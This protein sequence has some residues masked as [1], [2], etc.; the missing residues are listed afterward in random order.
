MLTQKTQIPPLENGD[1]LSRDEFERRYLLMP[2]VKKAELVEGV[3][4]MGSPVRLQH[5]GYP[6]ALILGW[7]AAY[8]AA[9]PGTQIA[10]NTTVRLDLNNEPQPDALLRWEPGSSTVSEDDYLEG[11]PELIVE[12]A[13]SSASIDL[14]DKL[15]VYQRNHVQEYLV[16]SVYEEKLD[17]FF[18][19]TEGYQKSLPDQNSIIKS[20]IFPGLWLDVSAL[21]QG[22]LAQVLTVLQQGIQGGVHSK[23]RPRM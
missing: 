17:W 9:T 22:N 11:P 7:L 6:H 1:R 5:H 12:I 16:W 19:Q 4:Y 13:A 14:R 20:Q 3:V 2:E 8:H 15:K 18:L 23:D 21:L 10:D